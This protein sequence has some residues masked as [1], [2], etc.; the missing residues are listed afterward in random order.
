M[1][2]ILFKSIAILGIL[3]IYHSVSGQEN[4]RNC[5][6]RQYAHYVNLAELAITDSAYQNAIAYYDSASQFI[7]S[8]FAKDRYNK[9]VCHALTGE[10]NECR[11]GLLYL[12]GKGLDR[13]MVMD[14]PAFQGFLTSETGKGLP[15]LKVEL[16]Y[17]T[18]LRSVYDSLFAADQLFRRKRPHDYMKHFGDTVNKIDASNVKMMNNLIAEYG[19]PTEDLIGVNDLGNL[20]YEFIVIHQSYTFQIYNYTE[21]ILKALEK[22]LIDINNA[23]YLISRSN[24]TNDF[25]CM[26]A[27]II[28]VVYDPEGTYKQEDLML[29]RHKTGFEYM[30][31]EYKLKI[32]QNRKEFGLEPID[33][34]RR[35]IIFSEN[36]KRFHFQYHGGRSGFAY[37]GIEDYEYAVK[38]IVEF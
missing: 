31:E 29:Y 5:N 30:S 17:N 37:P 2:N 28:T 24:N 12:F 38:N 6:I 13:Q 22:G 4:Q 35:K 1:K 20:K 16:T 27:G 3:G 32:E 7:G 15:D 8:P 33:E 26:D 34:F 14:N 10:F 18:R 19:W 21:D 25:K 9:T 23:A 36:D 11:S